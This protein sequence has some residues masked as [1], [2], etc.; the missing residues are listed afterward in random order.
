MRKIM[1]GIIHFR[2][3][4]LPQYEARFRELAESQSPDALLITCSDSRL[5]PDVLASVNPGELFV[6]RN[7]GNLVPPA[8]VDGASTGDL[9]EASAIEYSVLMLKVRHVIVCGHSQCGAM[10]AALARKPMADTP[11]LAKWLH[12]AA[13]AVF[14]LD[15][16]GPL[17]TRHSPC[18]QL[19]QLNVLV[20]LEHLASYPIVR[21]RLTS[22]TL[23]LS[24]WWFDIANGEMLAYQRESRKFEAIDRDSAERMLSR[25]DLET[26]GQASSLP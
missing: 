11:N 4:L 9:S 10:K 3:C 14:R 24:G 12:H 7:V 15:Q 1:M 17:D 21:D 2:E 6:M 23:H 25:L 5:L 22:G 26:V 20:Q 13:P 8:T 19:S 18:D 16:E